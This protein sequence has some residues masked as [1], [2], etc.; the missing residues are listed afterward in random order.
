MIEVTNRSRDISDE[1]DRVLGMD[2]YQMLVEK[3]RVEIDIINSLEN[4]KNIS[5]TENAELFVQF[6]KHEDILSAIRNSPFIVRGIIDVNFT[7][8]I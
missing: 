3:K 6:P 7:L 1:I 4:M 5:I 8:F 2:Y